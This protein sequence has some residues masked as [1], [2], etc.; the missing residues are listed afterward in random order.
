MRQSSGCPTVLQA[1]V[2]LVKIRVFPCEFFDLRKKTSVPLSFE[3]QNAASPQQGQATKLTEALLFRKDGDYGVLYQVTGLQDW[4]GGPTDVFSQSFHL[5][6]PVIA[7]ETILLSYYAVFDLKR[8]GDYSL[9][10]G[11]TGLYV[12]Q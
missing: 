2:G 10:L 5:Q 8:E 6:K 7:L 12:L 4:T 11:A 9:I 1:Q 3:F